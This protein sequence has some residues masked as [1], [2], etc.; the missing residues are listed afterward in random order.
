MGGRSRGAIP[1]RTAGF[2][3]RGHGMINDL[4]T[5]R[6]ALRVGALG[7]GALG[8]AA[9]GSSS[10][11]G[12]ASN[13]PVASNSKTPVTLNMLTW[14][15]HY[16]PQT[17]LP[18]IKKETGINVNVTLGSDDAAMFIKAQQSGQFDIV[19]A[20]ALWVP[21]Y[22]KNGLTYPFDIDEIPVSKQLYSVARE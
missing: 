12:A 7:I 18:A 8:L 4:I 1:R 22:Y 13:A 19:S 2:K 9:C 15:D 10:S 16:N 6:D 20:D 17:Q 11:S 5:R 3:R 21:Y 14:N